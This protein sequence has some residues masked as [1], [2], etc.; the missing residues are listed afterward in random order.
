VYA[1]DINPLAVDA[2]Q[3]AASKHALLNVT[4]IVGDSPSSLTGR[5][6]DVAIMHDVLHELDNPS[7]V[8]LGMAG[9]LKQQGILAVSDHHLRE[10]AL[11]SAVSSGGAFELSR[12]F[13]GTYCFRRARG[14]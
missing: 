3:R 7:A 12:S 1:L 6:I 2:V 4:P 10:G 9:V 14:R 5:G 13:R 11:I 8:L